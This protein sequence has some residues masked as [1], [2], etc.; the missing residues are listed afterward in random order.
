MVT[1][2]SLFAAIAAA[3]EVREADRRSRPVLDLDVVA[4]TAASTPNAIAM[5]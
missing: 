2:T 3:P 5:R 1:I 4:G